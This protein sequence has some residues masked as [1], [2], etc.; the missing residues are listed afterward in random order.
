MSSAFGFKED[1]ILQVAIEKIFLVVEFGRSTCD[2][3]EELLLLQV[4]AKM[5]TG[6]A[7]IL[8]AVVDKVSRLV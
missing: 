4:S 5:G 2:G 3:C 7:D 1:E 6:V 8:M